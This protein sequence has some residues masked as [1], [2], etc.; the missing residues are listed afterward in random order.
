MLHNGKMIAYL[1]AEKGSSEIQ[2]DLTASPVPVEEDDNDIS[3][4][5]TTSGG[6]YEYQS[7]SFDKS[8]SPILAYITSFD[9]LSPITEEN[10]FNLAY[11]SGNLSIVER[12]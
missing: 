10:L 12:L 8:N 7:D 6:T 5:S 4:I 9:E 1:A 2:D 3:F 11:I